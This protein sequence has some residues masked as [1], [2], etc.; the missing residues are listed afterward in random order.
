MPEIIVY[1]VE[2]RSV[3]QKRALVKDIADAVVKHFSAP[4]D[5]VVVQIVEC[6]MSSKAK[7]GVLFSD[8][9]GVT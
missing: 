9:F 3:E 8:K 2:G 4:I 5:A 6:P 1:A 7:G